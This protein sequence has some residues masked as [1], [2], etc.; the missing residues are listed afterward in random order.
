MVIVVA[1]LLSFVAMQLKP[2]QDKNIAIAKKYDILKSVQMAMD[3]DEKKDKQ[4][5]IEKLYEQNLKESFVIDS[6]GNLKDGVDAFEVD[7]KAELSKDLE[8]RNLPIFV[9][10]KSQNDQKYVI[11]MRGKGL[12]G[13]IWGYVSLNNDMNTIYGTTFDHK[14]ETPGLGAEINTQVFQEQFKNKK[15]FEEDEFVGI[16]VK[17]GGA[18]GSNEHAVDA[19]SGGTITSNGLQSMIHDNLQG[20]VSYFNQKRN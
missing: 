1:A 17:K 8:D 15:I 6:K 10:E 4:A 19:I 7:L 11:P 20:Y 3:A 13:P 12:W 14:S 9:F 18:A 5:Y 2:L 16:A